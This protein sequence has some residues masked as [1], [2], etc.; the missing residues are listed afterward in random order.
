MKSIL[1]GVL[2]AGLM[3]AS[4]GAAG[5]A[6]PEGNWKS[7]GGES[8]YDVTLCKDGRHL[9][10]QLA[11]LSNE[12]INDNSRPYLGSYIV[13]NARPTRANEWKGTVN[14][15]GDKLGGTIRL[16]NDNQIELTGCK[17]VF[18]KSFM[19]NRQQ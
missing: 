9:C 2:A 8:A 1:Q 18:C 4:V 17:F 7:A 6:S 3:L 19:L 11:W 12:P 14:Y 5:A 15:L 16:V 10:V 13:T